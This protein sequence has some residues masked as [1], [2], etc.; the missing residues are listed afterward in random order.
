[1]IGIST[2]KCRAQQCLASYELW[3][4]VWLVQFTRCKKQHDPDFDTKRD[5]KGKMRV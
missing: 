5:W 3:V 1:M 4:L 2:N